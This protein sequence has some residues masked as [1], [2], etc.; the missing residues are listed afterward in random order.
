MNNWKIRYLTK[1]AWSAPSWPTYSCIT[2]SKPG[3]RERSRPT[4]TFVD[5]SALDSALD[6]LVTDINVI[7]AAI[8][9]STIKP[10][11]IVDGGRAQR[12]FA[13]RFSRD[14]RQN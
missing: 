6:T 11:P 2:R 10:L 1:E 7:F 9:L 3:W 13:R 4:F 12:F 8:P 14:Q 5:P